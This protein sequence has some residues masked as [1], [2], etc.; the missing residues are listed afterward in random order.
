VIRYGPD[1]GAEYLAA[2]ILEP[3]LTA[4]G[5][6]LAGLLTD[7]SNRTL[8]D[9]QIALADATNKKDR[10]LRENLVWE[11]LAAPQCCN[12]ACEFF[13]D[14]AAIAVGEQPTN[15]GWMT[16]TGQNGITIFTATH[17]RRA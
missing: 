8:R 5:S 14:L 13:H 15:S 10:E 12:R 11:S 6:A 17:V 3:S 16:E 1:A 9:L 7:P 2:W 4:P